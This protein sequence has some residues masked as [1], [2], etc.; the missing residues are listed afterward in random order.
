MSD[1]YYNE[2]LIGNHSKYLSD[3][4]FGYNNHLKCEIVRQIDAS[5]LAENKSSKYKFCV[6]KAGVQLKENLEEPVITEVKGWFFAPGDDNSRLKTDL[7]LQKVDDGTLYYVKTDPMPREDL[8]KVFPDA[9]NNAL[10][11]FEARILNKDLLKGTM[12]VCIV[13]NWLNDDLTDAETGNEYIVTDV[14]LTIE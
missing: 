1:P 7:L 8:T 2:N 9:K 4:D 5:K 12:R 3:Y 10:C 11:G 13:P 6:E 14:T